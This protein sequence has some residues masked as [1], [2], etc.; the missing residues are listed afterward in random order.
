MVTGVSLRIGKPNVEELFRK[1]VATMANFDINEQSRIRRREQT[2]YQI[3][4]GPDVKLLQD[5]F[6]G[7]V[8]KKLAFRAVKVSE[9]RAMCDLYLDITSLSPRGDESNKEFD[10]AGTIFHFGRAFEGTYCAKDR[11]GYILVIQS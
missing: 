9:H 11:T 6:S 1:W 2:D 4:D 5:V 3:I 8:K 7:T 10:I